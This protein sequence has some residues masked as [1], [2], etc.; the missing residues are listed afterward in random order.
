M[1]RQKHVEELEERLKR[2]ESLLENSGQIRRGRIEQASQNSIGRINLK[3]KATG[4]QLGGS[5]RRH[6]SESSLGMM[7]ETS[8]QDA[9]ERSSR[10]EDLTASLE[11]GMINF[12]T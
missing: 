9:A 4:Q 5:E 7:L 12:I 2:M 1:N 6:D 3:R 8:D 11:T 10:F